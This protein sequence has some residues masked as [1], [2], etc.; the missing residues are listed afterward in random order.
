[1]TPQ[2]RPRLGDVLQVSPVQRRTLKDA[3]VLI[4]DDEAANVLLLERLLEVSDF[5]NVVSTTQSSEV[6]ALC[7]SHD[8]DLIVLDL[9]MP[10]P[11]G[12]E[13]MGMLSPWIQGPTKLPV[14]V[15][16]ADVNPETKRRALAAGA[17]DFLT[18]PLDPSEVVVRIENLLESRLLQLELRKQAKA[19][20]KAVEEQSQELTDAALECIEPLAVASAFRDDDQAEHAL[21]VARTSALLAREL[22]LPEDT[23]EMIGRAARLHDVGKIGLSDDVLL[24][25]ARL[26]PEDVELMKSHVAIGAEILGHGRSRLMK[27]ATEI[28]RT[29]HERWDGGGYPDG[30]RGEQ[31]PVPGRIVGLADTFDG[32]VHNAAKPLPEAVAEIQR[33]AGREFDPNVVRAFEALDHQDLVAP[34]QRVMSAA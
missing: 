1:V 10:D 8:P 6:V 2:A 14:L 9:H 22:G 31:I 21:R 13:V 4:V 29:H 24:H 26:A 15:A 7:T 11:D 18:K 16:T 33:L 3:C 17:R 12:F 5:T 19:L 34:A 30:L 27:L 32:L 25:P 20:E 28:A 23:V